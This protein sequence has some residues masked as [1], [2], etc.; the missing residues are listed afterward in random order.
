[1]YILSTTKASFVLTD[2]WDGCDS[3]DARNGL[4][5]GKSGYALSL[6]FAAAKSA[7]M[8]LVTKMY[9]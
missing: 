7:S 3:W 2:T 1:M 4:F 9:T 8:A 5:S 6:S